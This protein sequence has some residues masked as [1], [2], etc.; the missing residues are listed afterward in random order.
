[1]KAAPTSQTAPPR[2]AA[3]P[4]R[5]RTPRRPLAR[6]NSPSAAARRS[7]RAWRASLPA[8]LERD[9]LLMPEFIADTV[10]GEVSRWLEV[11]LP[12]ALAEWLAARAHRLYPR[13]A[14]FRRVL[15]GHGNR[16][17]DMHVRVHAA[18]D[19]GVVS[20]LVP[21]T[22]PSPAVGIL[23]RPSV[24][25]PRYGAQHFLNFFPLPQGHGSLRPT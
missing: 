5:P 12:D 24:A 25:A 18:L 6:G 1:M 20:A 2:R 16:G 22:L 11:E 17:R 4:G 8:G 15:N 14:H 23:P 13:Q 19:C 3:K 10:V 9:T 7:F 21:G